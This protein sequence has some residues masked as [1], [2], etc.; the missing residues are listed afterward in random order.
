MYYL[1]EVNIPKEGALSQGIF[2][3]AQ[4]EGES[5]NDYF[6]RAKSQWHSSCASAGANTDLANWSRGLYNE[7]LMMFKLDT[8]THY[9]EP[10]P[11][12]DPE[13]E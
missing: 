12:P 5:S 1:V 8:G 3:I 7:G 2:S 13:E 6:E 10:E 11:T 4:N 9:V